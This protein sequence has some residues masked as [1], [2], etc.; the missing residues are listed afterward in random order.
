MKHSHCVLEWSS[1]NGDGLGKREKLVR[2]KLLT[3]HIPH[4][5]V[6]DR[7]MMATA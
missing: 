2:Q 4:Q 5:S 6:N 7:A 1:T 3:H